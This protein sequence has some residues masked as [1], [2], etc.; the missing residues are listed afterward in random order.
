MRIITQLLNAEDK[1][2]LYVKLADRTHN[3]RTIQFHRV[4]K[5]KQIASE[6]LGFFVPVALYLG[7]LE[8]ADELKK[9]SND[10]MNQKG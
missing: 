6:T 10:V 5:Q 1:R 9:R 4:D 3:M 8:L 2:V 7:L